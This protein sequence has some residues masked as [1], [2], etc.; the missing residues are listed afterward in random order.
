MATVQ[1]SSE[2]LTYRQKQIQPYEESCKIPVHWADGPVRDKYRH[3]TDKFCCGVFLLYICAMI[4]TTIFVMKHSK[5]SNLSKIYDSSGNDCGSGKA[6][7]YPL[8]YM[9][10]FSAPYKSVCVS[11]CPSFDY[12]R[13]KYVPIQPKL[14]QYG[15]KESEPLRFR[16]FSKKY[17][18]LSSVK[19]PKIEPKEAFG[20]DRGWANNYFTKDQFDEYTAKTKIDCLKNK[21]FDS[22]EVDNENFFAYDSYN[23]LDLICIPLA[24]KAALTFNKVSAKLDFGAIGDLKQA[25]ELLGW[26]AGITL[27]ASL[28]FIVLIFFC[29]SIV[30]WLLMITMM[31]TFLA[32]G[33]FIIATYFDA[34]PFNSALNIVRINFLQF[35]IDNRI[36]MLGLAAACLVLSIFTFV[37]MIKFRKYIK[38]SIPLLSFAAHTTLKN[39]LLIFLSAFII[40]VQVGVFL[41]E[42]Y[43]IIRTYTSGKEVRDE[44]ENSPFVH[45]QLKTYQ[46]I[47]IA[48]HAFGVYWLIIVMNNF[49]DFITS[50]I[51]CNLYFK[52][53]SNI[54]NIHILC[55]CLTHHIGSI[56]WSILLLPT[57]LI[58]FVFGWL[59]YLLT[60]DEPNC[61][62]RFFRKLLCCCCWFYEK[63][64]DRFSESSFPLI[65]IGCEGFLKAN[66]RAYYLKEKYSDESYMVGFVGDL[67]G[68]VGKLLISFLSTYCC[69]VLYQKSIDLQQNISHVGFLFAVSFFIGFFI[70]S[71]LINLFATTYDTMVMCYLVEKNLK[72]SYGLTEFKCPDEIAHIMQEIHQEN[73]RKYGQLV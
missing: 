40:A 43:V 14:A 70:G 20:Y 10:T 35:L 52:Q 26:G 37:I 68:V 13:I 1:A 60:S 17:A 34:G 11:H 57:I 63:F 56:A 48:L 6:T 33:A 36:L 31:L 64:V 7:S 41:L 49:N 5:P 62:Q 22:C 50:A 58:K 2:G 25:A 21:Q 73:S 69:Y 32:T 54:K 24:P 29:T 65:Y 51:T 67:F 8:L 45:Y 66:K 42:A 12:N 16:E 38:L 53:H 18:G 23:L 55:H 19:S 59:D 47:I 30:T 9:M 61:L 46:I 4:G 3:I 28:C 71:L 15:G 27:A 44:K 72:E 39:I